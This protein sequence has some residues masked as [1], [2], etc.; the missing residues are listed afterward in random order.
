[1]LSHDSDD[2]VTFVAVRLRHSLDGQ[3]VALR[4]AG[5]EDNLF[6]GSADK[7][8]DLTPGGFH[9]GPCVPAELVAV[10][11]RVAKL[12]G[13]KRQHGLKYARIQRSGRMVIQINGKLDAGQSG[14][15]FSVT[16]H[17]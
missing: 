2:V 8:G 3:I 4:G 11:G 10:A 6:G 17:G 5:G 12:G 14:V 13:K 1:M 16:A 7:P 15:V 9:G